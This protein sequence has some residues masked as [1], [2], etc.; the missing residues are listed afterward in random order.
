MGF[1]FFLRYRYIP[2]Y[3]G[4]LLWV[5]EG[6]WYGRTERRIFALNFGCKTSETIVFVQLSRPFNDRLIGFFFLQKR[7]FS[8][9][10]VLALVRC[11]RDSRVFHPLRPLRPLFYEH[12]HLVCRFG[13]GV[14]GMAANE[15]ANFSVVNRA[16]QRDN[17]LLYASSRNVTT[18]AY[19]EYR[20]SAIFGV[21]AIMSV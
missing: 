14:T 1:V 20:K 13:P 12:Y 4:W 8:F 16:K 9:Y 3:P 15:P 19:H 2:R 21:S 10:V 6:E 17:E 18:S 11:G 7:R 5:A